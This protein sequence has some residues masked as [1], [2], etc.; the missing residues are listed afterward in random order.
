MKSVIMADSGPGAKPFITVGDVDSDAAKRERSRLGMKALRRAT[1]ASDPAALLAAKAKN[2][3]RMRF[4]RASKYN[5]LACYTAVTR[6]LFL[7]DS[8]KLYK[9]AK[10]LRE[11]YESKLTRFGLLDDATRIDAECKAVLDDAQ[12]KAAAAAAA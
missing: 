6:D 12:A 3:E 10:R 8:P 2:A 5:I 11:A 1:Q 4:Q 9:R 7:S